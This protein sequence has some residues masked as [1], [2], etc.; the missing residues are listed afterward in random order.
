MIQRFNIQFWRRGQRNLRRGVLTEEERVKRE[1]EPDVGARSHTSKGQLVMALSFLTRLSADLEH[2]W[3]LRRGPQC[4]DIFIVA[5]LDNAWFHQ[6]V[7]HITPDLSREA[8]QAW[9]TSRDRCN[10]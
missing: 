8:S 2:N 1:I 7:V 10:G 4:L 9:M 6:S 5:Q 3:H